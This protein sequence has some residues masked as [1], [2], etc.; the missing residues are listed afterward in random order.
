MIDLNHIRLLRRAGRVEICWCRITSFL[1]WVLLVLPTD[2]LAGQTIPGEGQAGLFFTVTHLHP[3]AYFVLFLV[4]LLSVANLVFQY[5]ISRLTRPVSF[6][7]SFLRGTSDAYEGPPVLKGLHRS[8]I[9]T[10]VPE[11]GGYTGRASGS[12][13]TRDE[14]VISVRKVT[15]TV[16]TPSVTVTP[17]PLEGVNHALPDLTDLPSRQAGSP[18]VKGP[19]PD[20]KTS[21][22]EFK[23]S[24]AVDVPTPEEVERR[25]RTHLVI[26][27]SVLGPDGK[28]IPSVI[29]Y[30]TDEEGNRVGQSC[31]SMPDTGEFK[32]LINEPGK[33]RLY[34]YKRGYVMEEGAPPPLP[35]ESGKIEGF[36]FRMIPEGCVVFGRVVREDTGKGLPE[37]E[38][39][40]VCRADNYSRSCRTNIEGEF[41]ISGVPVNSECFL[42]VR[43][44]GGVLRTTTDTFQT[45]QKREL[46]SEIRVAYPAAGSSEDLQVTPEIDEVIEDATGTGNMLDSELQPAS[47]T[48]AGQ[49]ENSEILSS[50]AP[51]AS[52]AP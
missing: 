50:G 29:V 18:R 41:R 27:G 40:C 46:Y 39:S 34:G 9:R 16:Q 33:Y 37:H 4:F 23:F 11:T 15:K 42:E 28:G 13:A 22:T 10:S 7:F 45:V 8:R 48:T 20:R 14:A 17:T 6:L 43:G 35:I 31:R 51:S 30:L 5:G 2:L 21:A 44:E 38:V 32:V 19:H 12:L 1:L 52:P 49:P 47:D 24:S 3:A 26:S 25:E 36:N